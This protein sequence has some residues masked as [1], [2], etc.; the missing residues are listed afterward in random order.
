MGKLHKLCMRSVPVYNEGMWQHK[1]H[2]PKIQFLLGKPHKLYLLSSEPDLTMDI[3]TS[4]LLMKP[5]SMVDL[6]DNFNKFQFQCY[7][8]VCL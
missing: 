1:F 8:K 4:I 5:S 7:N 2:P 3:S 6:M